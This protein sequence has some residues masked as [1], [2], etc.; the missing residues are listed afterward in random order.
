MAS[1]DTLI[2][3]RTSYERQSWREAHELLSGA[4][5]EEPLAPEDLDRLASCAYMLGNEAGSVD[6]WARAHHAFLER[7]DAEQAAWCAFRIGFLL[8]AKGQV[9]HGSGWLARARRVLDDAGIDSVVR[10]YLLMPE[11][12]RAARSGDFAGALEM[13]SQAL[14]AGQRFGDTDLIAFGRQGQGRAMIKMGRIAE[15]IALLDEVMVAVTAGELMP[16]SVGDIYCSVLDACTE[17]Y[18]LRRAHEWTAALARWC[19]AQSDSIP[20]RGT[21]LI[22]RAEILQLHGSWADAMGEAERACEQLLLPPPRPA[23]GLAYYQC[24]ELHRLRGEFDKA[25]AAFRQ[26][27]ELG[28]KPQPG[29]ALLRLAQGDVDAALASI[30]RCVDE[31]RD[32]GTRSRVLGA[33]V[34][35]LLAANDASS[36]RSAADELARIADGFD[37]PFLRAAA[38]HAR[39]AVSL[40]E[41]DAESA[42]SFLHDALAVWR[43][44]EAPYEEARTRVLIAEASRAIGDEDTAELEFDAARSLFQ[45][46]GAVGD[47][48]RVDGASRAGETA[49]PGRLTAREIEVLGLVA[50]GKTNRAIADALGLSE[51]TVARHIANIFTKLGLSSRAAAT[52]YAYQ[53]KLV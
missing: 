26:A 20:Y 38:A 3:A 7:G 10:G 35:I 45:R 50:T 51:K 29:L 14:A 25:E 48:A 5:R 33:C 13:F 21:C 2:Q 34:E 41:G 19:D 31:S 6:I 42:L 46:L 22:R 8:A 49:A 17:I 23:A 1:A 32:P 15:G 53:H 43:D 12:F 27:S 18:D 37:A 40:S 24:G 47:I 39:G 36:A 16:M 30:R 52:A 11:G 28:R 9:A 4:D 44:L